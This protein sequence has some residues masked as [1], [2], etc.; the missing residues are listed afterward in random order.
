M[1]PHCLYV[2][3]PRDVLNDLRWHDGRGRLDG[4]RITLRHRGGLGDTAVLLGQDVA[5]VT[6]GYLITR[7][8]THLPYHR[9]LRIERGTDVVWDRERDGLG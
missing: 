7:D 8:G 5:D 9:V 4:V 6:H 2:P 1:P 3:L